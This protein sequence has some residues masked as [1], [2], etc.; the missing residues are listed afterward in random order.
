MTTSFEKHALAMPASSSVTAVPTSASGW[1]FL[2]NPAA[3]L[4][5][6]LATVLALLV[7]SAS[8][9]VSLL[10]YR[11]FGAVSLHVVPVAPLLQVAL[12]DIAVGIAVLALVFWLASLMLAKQVRF[13]DFLMSVAIARAPL[14]VLGLLLFVFVPDLGAIGPDWTT[15]YLDPVISFPFDTLN[16]GL[17][18]IVALPCVAWFF[19]ALY[20]GFRTS[21]ELRGGESVIAFIVGLVVAEMVTQIVLISVVTT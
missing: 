19:A 17:V 5:G 15:V 10:G 11:F 2:M 8:V 12:I 6:P 9:G 14:V 7:T 13:V 1:S 3:S 20:H 18:A 21:S 16:I 4:S